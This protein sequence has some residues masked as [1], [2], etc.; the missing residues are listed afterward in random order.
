[1]PNL[2]A[3]HLTVRDQITRLKTRHPQKTLI[4]AVGFLIRRKCRQHP[5]HSIAE[6][7]IEFVITRER[8]NAVLPGKTLQFEP[9]GSHRDAKCLDLG[10]AGN[11]TTIVVG[12]NYNGPPFELGLKNALAGNIEIIAID[13]GKTT[14]ERSR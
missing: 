13:Q 9:G 5:H 14:H 3:H 4:D 10:T 1:M 11:R 6:I 2:L 12:E 7:G 8:Y